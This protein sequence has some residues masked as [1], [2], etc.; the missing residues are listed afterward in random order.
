METGEE[1]F[2]NNCATC[3]PDGGGNIVKPEFI[4]RSK[5]LKAH[6]ITE[7]MDI[8]KR[9]P[10]PNMTRFDE[11]MIPDKEVTEIAEYVLKN[12]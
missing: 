9:N 2:Q 1:L 12:F 5:S 7:P 3:H 4:L 8:V 6:N 11:T 10:N